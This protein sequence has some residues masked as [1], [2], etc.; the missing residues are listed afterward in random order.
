[1]ITAAL[2]AGIE[3]GRQRR[4]TATILT[5]STSG[6]TYDSDPGAL[7]QGPLAAGLEAE[8]YRFRD[9]AAQFTDLDIYGPH[10]PATGV[11]LADVDN[12]LGYGHLMHFTTPGQTQDT[13]KPAG[14]PAGFSY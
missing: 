13:K 6:N 11:L 4:F 5:L 2:L 8:F 12:A 7:Q 10:P 3:Q 14:N 1:M 9:H